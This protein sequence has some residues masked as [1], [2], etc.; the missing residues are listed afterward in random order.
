MMT[1]H[2]VLPTRAPVDG[3]RGSRRD[4]G[5]AVADGRVEREVW[6]ALGSVLDPELDEPVTDLGFVRTCRVHDGAVVIRLRLP[7]P[8]CAPNFAFLMT[9]DAYD[10]AAGVEGVDA[11]DVQLEDHMDSSQINAGVASQAGFVGTYGDEANRELEELRTTFRR[12]A[13]T[14]SLDYACRALLA[15]G[16]SMTMLHTATLGDLRDDERR[17][18]VRRRRDIGLPTTPEQPILVDHEGTPVLP[19]NVSM[20]LRFARTTRVSIDGNAHFC[21]GLLR[22]RYPG[23]EHDQRP[24]EGDDEEVLP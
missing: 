9:A 16:W 19:E 14:A 24:R 2:E 21:R 1:P 20:A 15:D 8:M 23:S 13:H 22:T 18:L 11:V 4:S 5:P 10:A 12:K 17:R 7:T 6:D 3:L